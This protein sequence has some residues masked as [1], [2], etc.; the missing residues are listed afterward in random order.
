MLER[1]KNAIA[2]FFRSL[3]KTMKIMVI[4]GGAAGIILLTF[5]ILF[6]TRTE[7][8]AIANGLDPESAREITSTLEQLGIPWQ[9]EAGLSVIKVP[10]KDVSRA[11]MELAVS[12]K[13]RNISW[14]DVFSADNFTMT[15]GTREQMYI[16]AQANDIKSAIETLDSVEAA[17]VMLSIPKDSNYF[18]NRAAESRASIILKLRPGVHLD[19]KSVSGIVNLVSSAVKGLSAD[20]VTIVDSG[21]GN[22]LNDFSLSGADFNASSQLEMKALFEREVRENTIRFLGTIYGESNV[23]VQA[24]VVLDF[25][26]ESETRRY[27]APPVEGESTGIIRSATKIKENVSHEAGLG[28][29]GTDTNSTS[30]TQGNDTGVYEKASETLNY[31]INESVKQLE[32]AEVKI[33]EL[34][35]AVLINTKVLPEG[36]MTPE[37]VSELVNLVSMSLNTPA[38]KVSVLGKEF[39]DKTA[40]YDVFVGGENS[41]VQAQTFL[42]ISLI[43]VALVVVLVVLILIILGK[44]RKR[45]REEEEKR[46]AELQKM[47]DN[48][49]E[50]LGE[51]GEK[52]DKGSPKYHIEKFIDKNP[53]AAVVLLRAW[54]NE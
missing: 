45:A 53:E 27:Y 39:A 33:K 40:E 7:Y 43:A 14:A 9:D 30:V 5:L 18:M 2:G 42:V 35:V 6:L 4:V 38:N 46:L 17:Q 29:P 41:A 47:Q 3:S 11:R 50:I 36:T 48:T 31:E 13:S 10:K 54:I 34:S 49:D 44:R 19:K 28:V 22:K 21:T 52:D 23:S 1:I 15:T 25:D 37:H 32:K 51:I 24:S 26:K 12:L 16:R 20:N 8:V